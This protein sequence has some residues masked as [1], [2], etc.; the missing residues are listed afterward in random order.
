[1]C[2]GVDHGGRR[3][4]GDTSA[5]RLKRYHNQKMRAKKPQLSTPRVV[6][7]ALPPSPV[8][9]ARESFTQARSRLT[10]L[11]SGT[12]RTQESAEAVELTKQI[13]S[14]VEVVAHQRYGCASDEVINLKLEDARKELAEALKSVEQHWKRLEARFNHDLEAR[15]GYDPKAPSPHVSARQEWAISDDGD[16]FWRRMR[17][18]QDAREV[19]YSERDQNRDLL[20]GIEAKLISD[21]GEALRAALA[22]FGVSFHDPTQDAGLDVVDSTKTTQE[23]MSNALIEVPQ[24]WV[25][26]SNE[27]S[28][29]N[30]RGLRVWASKKRSHYQGWKGSVKK[31]RI[32]DVA[33]AEKPPGWVPDPESWESV[34]YSKEKPKRVSG[35]IGNRRLAEDEWWFTNVETFSPYRHKSKDGVPTGLGW[36]EETVDGKKWWVRPKTRLA[37]IDT[38]VRSEITVPAGGSEGYTRSV[39]LHE[40]AHR[41]EAAIPDTNRLCQSFL[42][43]RSEGEALQHI[44]S[45]F[46]KDE[47]GF[48]DNFSV[49]YMGKVYS[50][51][52]H[53]EILSMGVE[54]LW[55]GRHGGFV[56]EGADPDYKTFLLGVIAHTG[57]GST[58]PTFNSESNSSEG[59]TETAA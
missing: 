10:T 37:Q 27:Y 56:G 6:S 26:A 47:L 31:K 51:A 33:V 38:E 43:S 54:S 18:V 32:D 57:L 13:G 29:V 7:K 5:A 9:L 34:L 14:A 28:R 19:Y 20:E 53:S 40:F 17:E 58:P 3:C 55:R 45:G 22:D 50:G 52:G 42:V 2:Q 48:R 59:S 16:E 36:R 49:P 11:L 12:L 35:W 15:P 46:R 25:D 8:E 1:M 39:A 23:L 21:R 44:G 4:P 41:T 24:T 30:G